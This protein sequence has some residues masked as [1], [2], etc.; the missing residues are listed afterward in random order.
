[1]A[2]IIRLGQQVIFGT[3]VD[4]AAS[5]WLSTVVL[6]DSAEFG[7]Q[8]NKLEVM[9]NV[10]QVAGVV[11]N[12]QDITVSLSGRLEYDPVDVQLGSLRNFPVGNQAASELLLSGFLFNDSL[13]PLV[14]KTIYGTGA[15]GEDVDVSSFVP[16][17]DN[18]S[19]SLSS[20][21][22]GTFSSSGSIYKWAD[23]YSYPAT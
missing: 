9:N 7:A 10:D 8:Y 4:N 15:T 2:N 23:A 6:L 3:A 14:D 16:V 22:I 17:L 5:P 12:R 21:A 1:M 13:A 19:A 20:S 18:T 11:L